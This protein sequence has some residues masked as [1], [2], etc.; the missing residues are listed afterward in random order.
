DLRDTALSCWMTQFRM[1]NWTCSQ[2]DIADRFSDYRRLMAHWQA[3]LP[4]PMLELDYEEIVADLEGG[5]RRLVSWLGLEWEPACLNFHQTRRPIRTAS[6]AQ[7][8]RPLYKSSVGRWKNYESA[9]RPLFN[10]LPHG[11]TA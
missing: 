3:C 1:L 11:R 7:V 9:L 4:V 5:S 8:R 6:A 2:A 10:R